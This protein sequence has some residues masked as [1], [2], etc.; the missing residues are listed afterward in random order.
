MNNAEIKKMP[1]RYS[2]KQMEQVME[3]IREEFGYDAIDG[4][5]IHEIT[6][7][8]V[9]TD[10]LMTQNDNYTHLVTCGMGAREMC[11]WAIDADCEELRRLE[12]VFCLPPDKKWTEHEIKVLSGEL[13]R[14]SKFPFR[15]DTF[16]APGHTINAS[17][18]FKEMFGFDSF[19]FFLPVAKVDVK[20]AGDVYFLVVIPVYAEEQAWMEEN[21]SLQYIYEMPNVDEMAK[22]QEREIFIPNK[23][24][25]S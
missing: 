9:H 12:L 25:Y 23:E 17:K 21:N 16:F 22:I 3:F 14:L 2:D 20:G 5:L 7:E 4:Y 15:E 13:V 1:C 6:S 18:V 11:Q 8:Y 19:L 24:K 10:V